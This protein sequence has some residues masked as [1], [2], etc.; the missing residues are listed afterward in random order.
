MNLF[1]CLIFLFIYP[2]LSL[3]EVEGEWT[4]RVENGEVTI[5]SS[6]ATGAVAIPSELGGYPVRK[7]GH[8]ATLFG[9]GNTSVSTITIPNGVTSIGIYAF[10]DCLSLTTIT[11]P[12][13]VTSIGDGAFSGC[14]G[15]TSVTIP[16]SVTSIGRYAFYRCTSL[17]TLTIP[18]SV[19]SIGK[20]AFE[21][22]DKLPTIIRSK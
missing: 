8:R 19:T 11:I 15:L 16:N 6:T 17:A 1:P 10:K 13:S 3:G 22:C 2:L 18:D 12:N 4:Y 9:A 7:V 14:S 21:K 5:E 20:N